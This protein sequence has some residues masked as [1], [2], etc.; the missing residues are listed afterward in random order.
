M[1][2]EMGTTTWPPPLSAH[3]LLPGPKLSPLPVKCLVIFRGNF[4]RIC[5]CCFLPCFSCPW[6]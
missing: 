3:L 6:G 1:T 4:R 5:S 2:E